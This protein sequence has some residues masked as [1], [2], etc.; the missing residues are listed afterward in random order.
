MGRFEEHLREI[1]E[2]LKVDLFLGPHEPFEA[3]YPEIWGMPLG[4]CWDAPVRV[5]GTMPQ[6]PWAHVQGWHPNSVPAYFVGLHELG[7][8]ALGLANM[9]ALEEYDG[10]IVE[11]EA[12]VWLWAAGEA[13]VPPSHK[14]REYIHRSWLMSYVRDY[15]WGS[16]PLVRRVLDDVYRRLPGR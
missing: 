12:A 11:A 16:G 4:R 8:H 14:V 9:W 13:R 2:G 10:G 15:G 3:G 7:H 1:A 5:M 6:G